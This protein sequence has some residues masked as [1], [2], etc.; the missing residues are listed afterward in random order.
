[1]HRPQKGRKFF[2]GENRMNRIKSIVLVSSLA[3]TA[4]LIIAVKA[5]AVVTANVDIP[6]SFAVI[7]PCN[8]ETV[9]FTGAD[10]FVVRVT[11]DGSGRFHLASNDNIHV[12]G[13]G[14]LG[15]E[16]EGNQEDQNQLNGRFG[17]EQTLATT[18]SAISTGSAP[19]YETHALI[20]IT[21]NANGTTTVFID[22]FTSSCPV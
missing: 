10:H 13:T 19:N 14:S 6:I 8:G 7:N 20:H 16:Y 18:F 22:N 12:T 2:Q 15:N 11:F 1:M 17:I 21:V 4:L 9:T 3:I 5:M